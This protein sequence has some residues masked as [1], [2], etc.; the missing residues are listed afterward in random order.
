MRW[1]K[2]GQIFNP[3]NHRDWMYSH[4]SNPV[5]EQ[6]SGSVYRIYFS[7]RDQEKRS[8]I[9][10]VD[11]DI[12]DPQKILN[13]AESPVLPPGE[14]GYFDDS[15]CTMGSLLRVKGRKYLY[16]LGWNLSVTVPWR[17]SIGLA[18][19]SENSFNFKKHEESP[20]LDRNFQ[21]PF[22]ISYPWVIYED[23]IWR[24]W[25]GSHLSWGEKQEDLI[26]VI[27]YAESE[28]G[29]NW[30]RTNQVILPLREPDEKAMSR[31]CVLK[32]NDKYRM[33]YAF[34][35]SDYRIGY[36][37]SENG[38]DWHR[39]DSQAGITVSESGWDSKSVEYASVFTHDK[40]LF[41]LYNGN[42]YGGTGFGLAL[43]D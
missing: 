22:T 39:L 2:L 27:K 24:M 9:G 29:I 7:T 12:Y 35:E 36:A 30:R 16:Y 34:R 13:I 28:N 26:H 38:I 32:L 41:M 8:S 21:D 20:V 11:I 42:S 43:L 23:G 31:P 15:G 33:W 3:Q 25:Y 17:N 18:C 37:E 10:Y 40:D 5:A 19:C 14:R 4:A 6:L 1:Q